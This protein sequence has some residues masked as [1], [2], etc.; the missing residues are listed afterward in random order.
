MAKN[1][2]IIIFPNSLGWTVIIFKS[3]QLCDELRTDPYTNNP[4]SDNNKITINIGDIFLNTLPFDFY[5]PDLNKC[6]EY[7][8]Q[9]HYY[10]VTFNGV[11]EERAKENHLITIKH[12]E[13]KN[14]YCKNNN[15]E[16]L[17]IP[18]YNFKDIEV[19]VRDFI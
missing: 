5:L 3:Y 2:I 10:P 9:H 16:L 7:D 18:Y 11:S 13:I 15:I 12:D 4:N 17:R 1:K 8:G 14:Q 19:I 6:I